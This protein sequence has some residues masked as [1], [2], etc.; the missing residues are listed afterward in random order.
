MNM[1]EWID[2]LVEQPAQGQRILAKLCGGAVRITS[3]DRFDYGHWPITHY[4]VIPEQNEQR[5]GL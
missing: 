2:I 3:Y 5:K 1:T 4:K